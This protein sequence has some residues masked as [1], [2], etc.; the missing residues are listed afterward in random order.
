MRLFLVQSTARLSLHIGLLK[1]ELMSI[2]S[3]EHFMYRRG[4]RDRLIA[5]LDIANRGHSSG[6]DQYCIRNS[7]K[8]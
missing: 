8:Q 5:V 7:E 6:F 2:L 3:V 1:D 4:L